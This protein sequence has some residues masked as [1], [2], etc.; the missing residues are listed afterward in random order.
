MYLLH[1]LCSCLL[2]IEYPIINEII[3]AATIYGL[4]RIKSINLS[5]IFF[6]LMTDLLLSVFV[7]SS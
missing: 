2:A 4:L 1:C 7:I 5:K 3:T 6:S